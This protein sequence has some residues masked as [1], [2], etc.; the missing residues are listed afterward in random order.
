MSETLADIGEFG[1][2]DR[3]RALIEKEGVNAPGVTLGIGDD[4]ASFRPRRGRELLITCD[5]LL[6][7]RHYLPEHISPHDLGWRAMAV[8]ISDIGSMGGQPLYALI[9]LGLRS[10]TLVADVL[11]IYRGFLAALNPY[12]GSIIGGNITK[13]REIF[14]DIT[15]LGEVEQGRIVR[16][17][18]A[19]VGNVIL[20]TG[21]PGQSAAG[22]ELL[23]QARAP[24]E[25]QNHPLVLEYNRP[26]PRAR[27]GQAIAQSGCAT[28]MIDTSDGFL[29]DLGHICKESGVGAELFQERLPIS[30]ALRQAAAEL[31]KNPYQFFLGDSDD[32]ELIITCAPEN[33]SRIR[34]SVSE[35]SDTPLTEVGSIVDAEGGIRL[36]GLDGAHSMMTPAGWDHFAR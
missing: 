5:A 22:L 9:S 28:A 24:A 36:T 2:I 18:A 26:T 13:S 34:V 19:Q 17:S 7:G 4:T 29:G 1:L 21:Y 20:V 30:E 32:Y 23:L 3:I 15:L 35:I 10:D 12:G 11:G 14:I 6:E 25:L 33:V 27:E 16:R 31:G 8:N